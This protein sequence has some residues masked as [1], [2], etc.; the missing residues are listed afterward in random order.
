MQGFDDEQRR[1]LVNLE[2][3]YAQWLAAARELD[4]PYKGS[5][6][7]KSVA[8][9][10]YLYHRVSSAPLVDNSLGPRSAQTEERMITF[11]RGKAA[12]TERARRAEAE[13][14]RF[15]RVGR[16]LRLGATSGAAARLL[17]HLDRRGLLG[18]SLQAVGTVAM[19]AYEAEAG[20][21]LFTGYDATQDFDLAWRGAEGLQLQ[22]ARPATLLAVLREVDP[23]F[24]RNTERSFQAISGKYEVEVLAAPSTLASFPPDDLVPLPGLVEQEWLLLGEPL[25]HVVVALDGTPAPIVAPDPRWMALHKLWLSA[26]PARQASKRPKDQAQGLLLMRAVLEHMPLY[27]LDVGFVDQVSPELAGW[28]RAAVEW[29]QQHPSAEPAAGDF[30]SARPP[31]LS[32]AL[33][34]RLRRASPAALSLTREL[35]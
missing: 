2:T 10:Q 20:G 23:L 31:A 30:R 15:A 7:W 5:L 14:T 25:R 26:K 6:R 29:V 21:R 22:S 19:A 1:T 13:T 11:Q 9:R 16:A 35:R 24:T 18:T 33:V 8:G 27:P 34:R 3:Y 12:A 17:R 4:G 28:L 32:P